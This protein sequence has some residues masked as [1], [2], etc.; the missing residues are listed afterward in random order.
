MEAANISETTRDWLR[1]HTPEDNLEEGF[2]YRYQNTMMSFFSSSIFISLV[3]HGTGQPGENGRRPEGLRLCYVVVMTDQL[4]VD[5][6]WSGCNPVVVCAK[7]TFV[8]PSVR[9]RSSNFAV[10]CSALWNVREI[11]GSNFTV[12]ENIPWLIFFRGA[13]SLHVKTRLILE[14][15]HDIVLSHRVRCVM[16]S[17]PTV[18][19]CLINFMYLKAL[20][21]NIKID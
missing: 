10:R 16:N 3:A 19:L 7:Y 4:N 15:G 14:T 9:L 12:G 6:F 1:L 5:F 2:C 11:P 20:F 18:E 17:H 21:D 13:L 8:H